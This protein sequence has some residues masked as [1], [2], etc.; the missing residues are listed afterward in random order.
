M[1]VRVDEAR[2]D[3]PAFKV[4]LLGPTRGQPPHFIVRAHR[5][6]PAVRNGYSLCAP[7]ARVNG[8]DVCVVEN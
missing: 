1:S 6:Q 4:E 3:G 5:Q 8:N 7:V 2:H